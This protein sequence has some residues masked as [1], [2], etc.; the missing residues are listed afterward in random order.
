MLEKPVTKQEEPDA[1][2]LRVSRRGSNCQHFVSLT[3]SSG[4]HE[5]ERHLERRDMSLVCPRGQGC[6]ERI[7]DGRARGIRDLPML[8][9]PVTLRLPIL[10]FACSACSHRPWEKRETFG[11]RVQWTERLSQ[12]VRQECLHGCPC[13]ELASRYGLSARP[14]FRWT[15]AKSRGGR[16]RKLGRVLGID[17]YARRKGH[18]S[19]TILVDLDNGRPITTLQGRR[20]EDVVAWF[21]SRP[22]AELDRVEVVVLD[23]SKS[24]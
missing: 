12:H 7:T 19:T 17:A 9:R 15:F 2:I 8:D 11:D 3:M 13:H 21:T 5:L 4:P 23:R 1:W 16:P 22:H 6:C 20:V 18:R 10:R 24:F 14:V